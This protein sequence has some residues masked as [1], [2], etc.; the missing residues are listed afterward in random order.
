MIKLTFIDLFAGIGGFHLAFHNLGFDCVFASEIDENARKSYEHNFKHISPQLFE[1][2]GLPH[3]NK[4]IIQQ[5][6][7]EIPDFDVLCAGFPCQPF[8]IA[9]HRKG[10]D[11]EG[12]GDLIFNILDII[13]EKKP[14]VAFLE[15]VKNLFSHDKGKTYQYIKNLIED[16]GYFVTEK[17]MNTM[18]YGDLPQ[19]RE[20]LYVLAFKN[21]EDFDK[22][23]FPEPKKLKKP[24]KSILEVGEI[25]SC[26]CNKKQFKNVECYV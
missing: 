3:F 1:G 18:E 14:R 8:S 25:D 9:G 6:P 22:F 11:D 16:E 2:L 5:D 10:F 13:R 26:Y 15:N 23:E 24:L 12:R 20:R 4:D 7:K 21:K 17:V 19:N